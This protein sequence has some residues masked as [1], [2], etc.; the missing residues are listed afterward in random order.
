VNEYDQNINPFCNRANIMLFEVLIHSKTG[1]G[2]MPTCF[3]KNIP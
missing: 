2:A 3:P 1:I